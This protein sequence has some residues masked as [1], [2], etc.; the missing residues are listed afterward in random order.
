LLGNTSWASIQSGPYNLIRMRYLTILR[1][2]SI[3]PYAVKLR[4][5]SWLGGGQE[6]GSL[7]KR[8]RPSAAAL[9][10]CY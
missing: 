9:A 4:N 1:E 3:S 6:P 7:A 5:D 2:S 8:N 10:K